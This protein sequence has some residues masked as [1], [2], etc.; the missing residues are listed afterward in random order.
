M[1]KFVSPQNILLALLLGMNCCSLSP[2]SL[3][4]SFR[5]VCSPFCLAWWPMTDLTG[6][7]AGW[8]TPARSLALTNDVYI[9]FLP[10][11]KK[12]GSDR[13]PASQEA[14]RVENEVILSHVIGLS[15]VV[16]SYA[17]QESGRWKE[18]KRRANNKHGLKGKH[19]HFLAM[20]PGCGHNTQKNCL[21]PTE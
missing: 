1:H 19:S 7:L 4:T 16:V 2:R 20:C 17:Q 6:W 3:T 18:K 10:Q 13:Q 11:M 8:L 5:S 9:P 15:G 12:R 14:L 21:T